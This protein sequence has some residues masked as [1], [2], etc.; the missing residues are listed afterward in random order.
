MSTNWQA[1]WD[2][3]PDVFLAREWQECPA[4]KKKSWRLPAQFAYYWGGETA[5]RVGIIA[6]AEMVKEEEFLLAG[7]QFGNRLSNGA[8]T[9][10]YYVAPNF[11][12][13]FLFAI[14]KFGH[15]INARAVYWKERLKPSLYLVPEGI[16]PVN[17]STPLGEYRPSWNGWAQG[18]NPVSQSELTIVRHFFEQF[19]KRGVRW[20]LRNQTILFLWGNLEIAEVRKKGKKFELTGKGKWEK[21]KEWISQWQKHGWIDSYGKLNQEFCRMIEEMISHLE[22]MSKTGELRESD[23][24]AWQ[25]YKSSGM[26]NLIWGEPIQCPW[27]S[28]DRS[29]NWINELNKWLYFQAD[30]KISVVCP[31]I[32]KPLPEGG[33]SVLLSSVLE[34]SMLF[35]AVKNEQGEGLEWEEVIHWITI[36]EWEEDLRLWQ[37]WLKNPEQFKVWVLPEGWKDNGIKELNLRGLV[38]NISYIE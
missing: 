12:P 9:V 21:R 30:G 5:L 28:K 8:R 11:S 20:E 24:L 1:A 31:V 23:L 2:A 6:S 18:L 14:N 36:P 26:G 22:E 13:Y 3:H 29:T 4:E 10:I 32:E 16:R 37:S 33:A 15:V 17:S 25:L 27:L 35:S 7:I 38:S 19:K 34:K